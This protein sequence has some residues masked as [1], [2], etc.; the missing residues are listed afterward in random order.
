MVVKGRS[1][2]AF[3]LH[4]SVSNYPMKERTKT[5]VEEIEYVSKQRRIEQAEAEASKNVV[6]GSTSARNTPFVGKEEAE[7]D[8]ESQTD[9]QTLQGQN[10]RRTDTTGTDPQT[11]GQTDTHADKSQGRWTGV[12]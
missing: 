2:N 11:E 1:V 3:H 4:L 8:K 5:E 10:H 9:R 6:N 7:R 12:Q